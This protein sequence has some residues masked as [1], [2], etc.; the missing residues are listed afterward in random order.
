MVVRGTTLF[1]SKSLLVCETN[2]AL[3]LFVEMTTGKQ[4]HGFAVRSGLA[5]DVFV[6]NAIVDMHCRCGKMDQ[7]NRVFERM[8]LK[9]VVSWNAMVTGYSHTGRFGDVLSLFEQMQQENIKLDVVTWTAVISGY[10]QRGLGPEALDVFRQMCNCVSQSNV[11]TLVYLLSGCASVGAILHG[12]ETH[13]YAIKFMLNLDGNDPREDLMVINGLIDMYSKC[14]NVGVA[15]KMFEL[16]TRKDMDVVTWTVMIGGYAQHGD[17]NHALQLFSEMF[18][19]NNSLRLNDFTLSCALMA[20]ARLAALRLGRQ[21][22]AYV[23][24]NRYDSIVLFV[25]NCL[26][27]MYSKCGDVET[28]QVVFNNMREKNYVSWTTL[29]TGDVQNPRGLPNFHQQLHRIIS[30]NKKI[31]LEMSES[32]WA[33]MPEGRVMPDPR[34]DWTKARSWVLLK[35][36]SALGSRWNVALTRSWAAFGAWSTL[37]LDPSV[38]WAWFHAALTL[39]H[40]D[41]AVRSACGL[42]CHT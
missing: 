20:C 39:Q 2:A 15:R 11:V 41:S 16:I 7:A 9:D 18:K 19:M 12:K 28:A 4:V 14:I 22:H 13:Y 33:L 10:A 29:M 36:G 6:G 27:D 35:A 40:E 5:D 17:G 42:P 1:G 8:K 23:L 26:I 32:G 31:G 37:Q 38:L 24:R 3:R 25:A 30:S 34:C 21:F